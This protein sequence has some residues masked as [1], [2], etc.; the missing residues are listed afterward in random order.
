MNKQN[1]HLIDSELNL[2]DFNFPVSEG[3]DRRLA[4]AAARAY[5]K[6]RKAEFRSY[7]LY[8]VFREI[9]ST[10]LRDIRDLKDIAVAGKFVVQVPVC[11]SIVV[12]VVGRDHELTLDLAVEQSFGGIEFKSLKLMGLFKARGI[13]TRCYFREVEIA[14]EPSVVR[15]SSMDFRIVNNFWT[16][17]PQYVMLALATNIRALIEKRKPAKRYQVEPALIA[18]D[19]LIPIWNSPKLFARLFADLRTTLPCTGPKVRLLIRNDKSD[20]FATNRLNQEIA[21]LRS[22]RPDLVI[23]LAH[24]SENLGF[25]NNSNLLFSQSTADIVILLTSDIRLPDDWLRRMI[26]PLLSVRDVALATPFAANGANLD[27]AVP[28]G[29]SWKDLDEFARELNPC[30]PDAETTVGYCLAL[31]RSAFMPSEPLFDTVYVNGYGDDSDLYYRMVNRGFRGVVVDNMVIYHSGGGS[32]SLV[33]SVATLR[34]ENYRR[35]MDRWHDAFERRIHEKAA[36]VRKSADK[37]LATVRPIRGVGDAI[38]ILPTGNLKYGGVKAVSQIIEGCRES[39]LDVGGVTLSSHA[40]APGTMTSEYEFFDKGQFNAWRVRKH[41]IVLAT[42]HSTVP[43]GRSLADVWGSELWYFVQGPEAAFSSGRYARSV[44]EGYRSVDRI[45]CVSEYLAD[46]IKC[47]SGLNAEVIH[48][49]PDPLEFYPGDCDRLERG[50]AIHYGGRADKGSDLA[51]IAALSLVARGFQVFAF[52]EHS[53][54]MDYPEGVTALGQLS[55]S[56]LRKLFQRVP[57]YVDLSRFEGLGLLALEATYCGAT[58]VLLNNGGAARELATLGIGI[59][60]DGISAVHRLG[61]ICENYI[62]RDSKCKLHRGAT[63]EMR[64]SLDTAIHRIAGLID[65]GE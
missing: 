35:F 62:T 32:F 27:I 25:I 36:A 42:S 59:A 8:E 11:N 46:M 58:P 49:G 23:E 60:L 39:G 38:F 9:I 54:T 43:W 12:Y 44:L 61:E 31:K 4:W 13:A 45:L 29:L 55:P 63:T 1:E 51:A 48:L 64:H 30:F 7:D 41:R 6:Y 56:G 37:I 2:A 20:E 24:N 40:A 10:C 15:F 3:I 57:I 50:V 21:N 5:L 33:D 53:G 52:G 26:C 34:E 16:F 18:V 14:N 19:I 47:V 17:S 65:A 22:A 28:A